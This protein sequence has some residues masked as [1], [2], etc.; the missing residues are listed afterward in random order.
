ML[1]LRRTSLNHSDIIVV[2]DDGDLPSQTQERVVGI[3]NK[4]VS[5]APAKPCPG[6]QL[7]FPL[8]QQAHT[9]YPFALHTILPLTWDYRRCS[10]GFFLT[11]H[12]CTGV[13]GRNGRCKRC[14]DL[15]ND[16]YL[17]KIVARYTKGIHEN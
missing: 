11:S 2:S 16:E 6:Y 4:Q 7:H 1:D 15:V 3:K 9:S 17:Q 10:D 5:N 8:G 14:D 12:L 13:A